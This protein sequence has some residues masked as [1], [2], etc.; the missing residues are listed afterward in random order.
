MHV[1]MHIMNILKYVLS[2]LNQYNSV[3]TIHNKLYLCYFSKRVLIKLLVLL[4]NVSGSFKT[5]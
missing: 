4:L 1:A 2:Q 5:S 3:I